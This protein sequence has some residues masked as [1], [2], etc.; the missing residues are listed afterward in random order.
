MKYAF[1]RTTL[2][3]DVSSRLLIPHS[4][5][6]DP[7]AHFDPII[8]QHPWLTI[9]FT[10]LGNVLLGK[11]K[12]WVLKMLEVATDA[13]QTLPLDHHGLVAAVCKD[14]RIAERIDACLKVH[15]DRKVSPGQAV[16]ALILNGLGFTNRRLYL[17]PQ[18]FKSK[19]VERL[20]DA[21]IQAEDLDDYTL[22][23]ALDEIHDYGAS[24]LFG[25]VA[26]GVALENNLLGNLNHLDTTSLSVTGEYAN[27]RAS[28]EEDA[29]IHITH[30]HSKDHRPDLKQA[31]LSLVVN[32][33]ASL[34][35]WMEPLNGNSSDKKSFHETVKRVS[36]FQKQ[37]DLDRN[38]K[39]VAD[40]ALYTADKLLLA[41]DHLWLTRVPE[42]VKEARTLV[43]KA[44]GEIAWQEGGNGYKH[45]TYVSHHGGMKQRWLLVYSEEAHAREK[46][47]LERNLEKKEAALRKVIWHLGNEIFAC[48]R[49][50]EHKVEKLKAEYPLYHVF[51]KIVPVL[52][53]A[54]RGKPGADEKPVVKGYKVDLMLERKEEEVEALLNRKGRFILATNDMDEA[55]Y[56]D[57]RMLSEYKE[58]QKVEG[59]FRFLKDPW[60]MVDSVFLKLPSRI[61]A[62]MMVMT[63]CLLVYN[64]AQYRLRLKLKEEKETLPNQLEKEVQNPTVRWIFQIMEG[65]GLVR[66]YEE[67]VC[68]P[69]R[70]LVTNL[71]SLR[72][73]IIQLFGETACGMYGLI[74]KSALR[75]PGM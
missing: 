22:G 74:P 4:A 68:A 2:G 42:T 18:F 51:E 49:D 58:Q 23:H 61:E 40:S 67:G 8:S 28:E 20:L 32:G 70:E 9:C 26:F 66:F 53:Y 56:P 35:L 17:T 47:T 11:R 33:P 65:I 6:M 30:G 73:K 60:F 10:S 55:G 24:A 62:L 31:V 7:S 41:K 14:L 43:S 46:K 59:G 1:E 75:A 52:K 34:P 37:I 48:E 5:H 13:I 21:P 57:E 16:V 44:D 69:I 54:S 38:F 12:E 39:W 64:V 29:V 19:P 27:S 3:L 72:K 15:K 63:L 45:A 71:T 50:A 36:A 25:T